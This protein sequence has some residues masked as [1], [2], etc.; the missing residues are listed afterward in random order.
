MQKEVVSTDFDVHT[1]PKCMDV[2]QSQK[3]FLPFEFLLQFHLRVS[4]DVCV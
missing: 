4:A 2:Q 1:K 3:H